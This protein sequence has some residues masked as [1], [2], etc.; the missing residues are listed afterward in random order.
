MLIKKHFNRLIIIAFA[1]LPGIKTYPQKYNEI[2]RDRLDVISRGLERY[3]FVNRFESVE[4]PCLY[5]DSADNTLASP[6][7]NIINSDYRSQLSKKGFIDPDGVKCLSNYYSRY[8]KFKIENSIV[9]SLII[10]GSFETTYGY[11]ASS[12]MQYLCLTYPMPSK[13]TIYFNKLIRTKGR[14][15]LFPE[16]NK[17]V[18]S[19][20]IGDEPDDK[21]D[22]V[23]GYL[24]ISQDFFNPHPQ[25]SFQFIFDQISIYKGDKNNQISVRYTSTSHRTEMIYYTA[26]VHDVLKNKD[27]PDSSKQAYAKWLSNYLQNANC[28]R[29]NLIYMPASTLRNG[30]ILPNTEPNPPH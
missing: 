3:L 27:A 26:M 1:L 2:K 7:R 14:F 17:Y 19:L 13:D 8:I 23:Y 16:N 15:R 9:D 21:R 4:T 20:V 29:C 5:I 30:F 22:I 12:L 10:E 28:I 25:P 6:G 24:E 11:P 18:I